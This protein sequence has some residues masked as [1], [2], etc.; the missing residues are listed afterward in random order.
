MGWFTLHIS[1]FGSHQIG[2]K[3]KILYGQNWASAEIRRLDEAL[4]VEGYTDWAALY[5]AGIK[6]ALGTMGTALTEEHAKRLKRWCSKVVCLFD[7][8]VFN[9]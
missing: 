2:K 1:R 9:S 7:H 4:I 3:S 8:L 5:I 6:N